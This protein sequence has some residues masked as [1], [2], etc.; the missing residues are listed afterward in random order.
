MVRQALRA[1]PG[2]RQVSVGQS[3]PAPTGGWDAR[4]PLAAMPV[5]NAVT[6]DNMI[7]RAGSVDLRRGFVEQASGFSG[8]VESLM[9]YRGAAS[10]DRLF[11]AAGGALV[12]AT[13]ASTSPPPPVWTGASS[14]RWNHTAFANAAGAWLIACNGADP[15]IGYDGGAWSVL[16]LAGA[17]PPALVP[18]ALASVFAHKGRLYFL[19]AGSLRVWVPAAGAVGG[20]CALVD[21][22]S[23]FSKGGRL[24]CGGSWSWQ[25]GVGADDF[26]VFATDQGQVAI[27][28][29]SDPT[30]AADWSLVGVYDFGPPLGPRALL[31]FGG[32][33][34]LVT[35]DGVIPLS[36]GLKLD[37]GAQQEVALTGAI[38]NAFAQAAKAHGANHGWQG[39]LYPGLTASPSN[40]EAAGGSL[41]IFNVPLVEGG[42]AW[43]FVQNVLT[44]AWCRFTGI[45]AICWELANQRLYFGAAGGVYQWDVGSDDDG[46]PI[47][48]T[49]Q[50]AFSAFGAPGRQKRFTMIRALLNTSGLVA[51]ALD[52]LADYA[53][54]TPA[55]VATV[56][57]AAATAQAIRYD[58]TGVGAVG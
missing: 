3:I 54:G 32:D 30:S 50:Q 51:P 33:L 36:R 12:D 39:I 42:A 26:A 8:P 16:G 52:I 6:L 31:K 10:G 46:A 27:W 35:A 7:P 43:Q 15:P 28:Q 20:A 41:A 14:D 34:A 21:L 5:Q 48:A 58:W 45:D 17:G 37:R 29:G 57:D 19:E 44:G 56:V 53:S 11:A 4:N 18:G 49:V 22:A 13:L 9:A 55:A 24:V 47:V 25:F 38:M 40:P 23:I 1:N 2:R